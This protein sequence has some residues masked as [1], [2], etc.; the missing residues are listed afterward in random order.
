MS[1][2]APIRIENFSHVCVGVSDIET[3]LQFYSD[4]LGMDVVFDVALEGPSLAAVTGREGESGRMV[5]GLIGGV[6]VELLE[7]GE[8]S[9]YVEGP[10][11]GYTNMSLRVADVSATYEQLQAF[12][13]VRCEPP[14]DIGGVRML[15]LYDPDSTPIELVELPGGA[16]TTDQ[17]WRPPA[18]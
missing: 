13:V 10:H 14:V 4:V 17:M 6:M 8:V 15:F 5:G 12:G 2:H 16:A 18:Q 11:I 3:A 1:E 9:V 7:L